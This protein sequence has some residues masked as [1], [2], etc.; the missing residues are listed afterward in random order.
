MT[1]VLM[2]LLLLRWLGLL[3]S[4]LLVRNPGAFIVLILL[5][6]ALH[7]TEWFTVLTV[8]R[9]VVDVDSLIALLMM[10]SLVPGGVNVWLQ[11][12]L[13]DSIRALRIVCEEVGLHVVVALGF[14]LLAALLLRCR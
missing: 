11:A 8:H 12:R 13:R 14:V 2:L 5:L 3:V 4:V 10:L 1:R 9:S 6:V 7:L